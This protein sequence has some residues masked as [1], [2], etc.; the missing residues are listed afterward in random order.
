M[1]LQ[2]A[3]CHLPA[4]AAEQPCLRPSFRRKIISIGRA[5]VIIVATVTLPYSFG[6]TGRIVSTAWA[7]NADDNSSGI[8]DDV[9][10]NGG[11]GTPH[12][13]QSANSLDEASN[14]DTS[15]ED[16]SSASGAHDNSESGDASGNPSD[17][18]T[19]EA[20]KTRTATIE[21]QQR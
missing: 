7:E 14:R 21:P 4:I 13:V 20:A 16:D 18:D 19:A 9:H 5:I 10:A 15:S 1:S 8:P 11:T 6:G 3:I 2:S 12:D 17:D